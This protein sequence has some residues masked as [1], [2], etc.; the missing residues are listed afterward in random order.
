MFELFSGKKFQRS[1]QLVQ[2]KEV[3]KEGR[4]EYFYKITYKRTEKTSGPQMLW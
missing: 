4:N 3:K 1:D 2:K